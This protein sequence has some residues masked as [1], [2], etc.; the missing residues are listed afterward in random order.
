M[1]EP[2][3]SVGISFFNDQHALNDAIA[4]VFNQSY[5]NWQLILVDDGSTDESPA[6]AR[7]RADARVV[8]ISDGQNKGLVER[9]NQLVALAAGTYFARMDADDVMHPER[10]E[11][12]VHF[13]NNHPDVDVVDTSMY[14]MSR[15]G[16]VTGERGNV[17]PAGWTVRSVLFGEMLHHAT[18]MGRTAWFRS[19]PYDPVY[20]RAE[21]MEL[22]CRSV[23]TSVFAR[24]PRPLYYVREGRINVSNY[25]RSQVTIRR[26]IREHGRGVLK[27]R[28]AHTLLVRSYLKAWLYT[29]MGWAGLQNVLTSARNRRLT[30]EAAAEAQNVLSVAT[31]GESVSCGPE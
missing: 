14:A 17:S 8:V 31:K 22:W 25:R 2:L 10:L 26:I 18:V 16:E 27:I 19:H 28:E 21:D 4:S 20:V 11:Q 3:V 15:D 5:A 30:P 23:G 7:R 12:Q 24:I 29:I 9:L 6:I 13:L 1:Q